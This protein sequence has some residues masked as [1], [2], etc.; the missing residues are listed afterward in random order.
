MTTILA[1][2][3]KRSPNEPDGLEPVCVSPANCTYD[4]RESPLLRPVRRQMSANLCSVCPYTPRDLAGHYDPESVLY[5][6]AKCDGARGAS[7]NDY[8]RKVNRRQQCAAFPN[9]HRTAQSSVARSAAENLA[10][11]GTT[12]GEPPSVRRSALTASRHVRMGTADGCVESTPPDND[13]GETPAAFFPKFRSICA[14]PPDGRHCF[15]LGGA[16]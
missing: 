9:V 12:P 5:V 2:D 10:S 16:A 11:S 3:I 1:N 7:T 8:P 4:D 15:A 6:Y 14:P 13:C